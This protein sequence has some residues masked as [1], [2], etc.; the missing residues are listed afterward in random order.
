[1]SRPEMNEGLVVFL[2][3][4]GIALLTALEHRSWSVAAFWIA[5]ATLFVYAGRRTRR[6]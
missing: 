4:F 5:M 3:F 1:M 6:W 2:L